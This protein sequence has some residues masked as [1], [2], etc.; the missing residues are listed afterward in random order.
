[1]KQIAIC[2]PKGRNFV[3]SFVM[4]IF[5]IA[6]FEQHN[7][8]F[9]INFYI[10][11]QPFLVNEHDV[12]KYK[13]IGEARTELVEM[14]LAD[15]MDY[16]WFIDDDMELPIDTLSRLFAHDKDYITGLGFMKKPPFFP[17]IFNSKTFRN[18]E[19][20]SIRQVYL[21][22]FDY[23]K[24]LFEIEGAGLFNA[25]IKTDVFRKIRK[26]YFD[27]PE[28]NK[29]SHIGEDISL[30]RRLWEAGIKMYCDPTIISGHTIFDKDGK[31]TGT[32]VVE[33][34][35]KKCISDIDPKILEKYKNGLLEK[36]FKN[37]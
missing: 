11:N 23:P 10:K 19:D 7:P 14:A 16:I 36:D 12:S 5:G 33:E 34:D 3:N 4:S 8:D 20:N 25:L 30:S 37:G 6:S 35:F 26:P 31:D 27:T 32:Q 13:R 1:M 28:A 2:I 18:K 24:E 17:T 22:Y 29:A 21:H 15:N 9:H